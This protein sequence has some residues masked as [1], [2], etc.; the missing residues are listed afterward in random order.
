MACNAH[1][2]KINNPLTI[3][4]IGPIVAMIGS[5]VIAVMS[6]IIATIKLPM[7]GLCFL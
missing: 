4:I 1:T 5:R 2:V 6:K 7:F 3:T